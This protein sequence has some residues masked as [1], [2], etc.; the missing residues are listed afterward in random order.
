MNSLHP[1]IKWT[2]E[3][4]SAGKL[5]IFDIQIIRDGPLLQTTVYRKVAASDRYIHYTSEQA[6]R[7][8]AC[9]IRPLRNRAHLYCSNEELLAD[10]LAYLLET[11][12]QNGY[13]EAMYTG[14]YTKKTGLRMLWKKDGARHLKLTFQNVF[15]YHTIQE[16][17]DYIGCWK[18]NL[19]CLWH[20]K[21]HP[22]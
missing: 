18:I 1:G 12:I 14:N 17:G 15:M 20:T 6:W 7:E 21:G 9:A 2:F 10:E 4:E 11:F 19:G 16:Q 22:H 8:K 5:A 3:K 13:P